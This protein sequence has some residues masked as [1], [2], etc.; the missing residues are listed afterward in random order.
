MKMLGKIAAAA[1]LMIVATAAHAQQRTEVDNWTIYSNAD[2]CRALTMF[3]SGLMV[4]ITIYAK[5]TRT[6]MMILDSKV[7][8]GAQD[9][10]PFDGKLAFVKGENLVTD[11]MELPV[12]GV[13]LENG[14]KGA[15]VGTEGDGILKSFGSSEVAGLLRGDDALVSFKIGDGVAVENA[16]R[17]CVAGK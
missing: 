13:T 16:L 17:K 4:S 8:A 12:I 15:Y 3:D 5:N 6:T 9:N 11:W 1:V 7:F 14:T 10:K 2:N